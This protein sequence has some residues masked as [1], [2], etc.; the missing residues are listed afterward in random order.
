MF[1]TF[2]CGVG[3][4]AACEK[5]EVDSIL[6]SLEQAGLRSQ[7]IGSIEVS[8]SGQMDSEPQIVWK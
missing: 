5:Q 6:I 4:I 3:M 8:T 2:N 1:E 7:I